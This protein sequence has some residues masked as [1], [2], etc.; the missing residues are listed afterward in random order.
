MP[1]SIEYIQFIQCSVQ[2]IVS[3]LNVFRQMRYTENETFAYRK[4]S[5]TDCLCKKFHYHR[6]MRLGRCKILFLKRYAPFFPETRCWW[7]VERS[8]IFAAQENRA[9]LDMFSIVLEA[10]KCLF[11][12]KPGRVW[13]G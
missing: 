6:L 11:V 7:P 2:Y 1:F 13:F 10:W 8:I 12:L 4:V 9:R 5:E 3:V